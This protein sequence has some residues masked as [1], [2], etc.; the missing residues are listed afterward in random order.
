M[1]KKDNTLQINTFVLTSSSEVGSTVREIVQLRNKNLLIHL[2]SYMHNTVLVQNLK[3]QLEK[4]LPT[5]KLVML[6]YLDKSQT[7]LVVYSVNKKIDDTLI[8]DEILQ[9]LQESNNQK[10]LKLNDYKNQLISKYFTD[11]LT[12]FPNLYQLRND[13][14]DKDKFTLITIAID[15]F[16]TFNN[17]YGFIIGDYIIEQIG[18]F[19]I[20]NIDEKIYRVSGTEFTMYLEDELEFYELKSYLR[21]LYERIKNIYINYQETEISVSLTL[22]SCTNYKQ[23]N[24]FSKVSMAL[25]YAKEKRL[26]FWIYENRMG[27]ENEYEKNLNI[28]N[29][30]RHAVDNNKIIPYFQAII[31]NK[32]SKIGRY[33]CLARLL[34]ENNN[35]ISPALFIPI[36]KRIKV[37]DEVTKT[38]IKKSFEIFEKNGY[39]FSINLSMEDIVNGEIYEFILSKLKS[40][41]ASKR[42][43]FE[44]VESE[45]VKDFDKIMRFIKEVRRYGAKIAI[46]DFGDGYSNF[47]YLIKMNVDFLKIDG[48]LIENIDTDKNS[49]LIVET[50]IEFANKLGIKVIAE[51]VHSSTVMDKVV[52]M[53][54]E[55]SQG[56][57]I[58][59]PSL[60]IE[61]KLK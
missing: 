20:K 27:F 30:V 53:G 61:K 38:I 54:I 16:D 32:T 46:D 34:D 49:Y 40:S 9:E 57:Y 8:S 3:S 31:D 25:K 52:D 50:I 37:Y 4:N 7:T 33:E 11:H 23:E 5:V 6:K 35:V 36:S 21:S 14:H 56:F 58:D 24:V 1:T 13:L 55:Y 43:I 48:S 39:D 12:S 10:E 18:E 45:A 41:H 22:A 42:V 59:K 28:S 26:P 17:F 44:I 19:L 15:N 60:E 29:I 51:Y 47:S 2:L